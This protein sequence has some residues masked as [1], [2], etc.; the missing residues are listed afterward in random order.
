MKLT[1]K[2]LLLKKVFLAL[3]FVSIWFGCSKDINDEE[4]SFIVDQS[5]LGIE[6]SDY[7]LGVKFHPPKNWELQPASL[8]KKI[9]SR[10]STESFIYE[11]IYL[12]FNDSSQAVLSVGKV[13]SLDSS[14]SK[15]AQINFYKSLLLSKYKENN[16]RFSSFTHNKINFTQLIFEKGNLISYKIIFLNG[17][18]DIIQFD[19]S[20]RS[21][22][23]KNILINIK[24]SIG[25]IKLAESEK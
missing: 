24:A 18:N 8:S 3:L 4:I 21:E 22:F 5:K 6:M 14:V 2:I 16:V 17:D 7:D 12:F 25:S 23:K 1:N 10:N 11:P 20:F 13:V 19:F 9:E 15:S